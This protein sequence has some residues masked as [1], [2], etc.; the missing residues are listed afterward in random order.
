MGQRPEL[1]VGH[2]D[3]LGLLDAENEVLEASG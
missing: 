1:T 2:P 3:A